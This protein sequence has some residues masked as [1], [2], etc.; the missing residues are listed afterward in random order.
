MVRV[1][2]LDIN[3]LFF[4][5]QI[6]LLLKRVFEKHG[7]KHSLHIVLFYLLIVLVNAAFS[8]RLVLHL[9]DQKYIVKTEIL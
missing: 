9:F 5:V 4:F 6:H 2:E 7:T 1:G 8:Q 3:K